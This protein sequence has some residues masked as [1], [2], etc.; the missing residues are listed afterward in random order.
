MKTVEDVSYG[1][2]NFELTH[3]LFDAIVCFIFILNMARETCLVQNGMDI[4]Y[5]R[6]I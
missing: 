5:L 4:F 3:V 2:I 6:K 1:D